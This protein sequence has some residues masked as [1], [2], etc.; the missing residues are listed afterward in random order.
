MTKK[1]PAELEFPEPDADVFHLLEYF[2]DIKKQAGE[3]ITYNELKCFME[4]M[5]V[6]LSAMQIE[7]IMKIDSIFE[8][9]VNG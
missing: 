1:K 3:K 7:V 9:A 5:R 2:F 6:D 8:G 4:L